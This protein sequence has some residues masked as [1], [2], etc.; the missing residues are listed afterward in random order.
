MPII[1]IAFVCISVKNEALLCR[2]DKGGLVAK[3]VAFAYFAFGDTG[4][5]GFVKTVEFVF[6]VFCLIEEP[7]AL[8]YQY[9]GIQ[10]QVYLVGFY[11]T[12]YLPKHSA[13]SS[14]EL[15]ECGRFSFELFGVVVAGVFDQQPFACSDV[16]LPQWDLQPFGQLL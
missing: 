5:I 4:G 8:L 15:F 3:L 2:R 1:R 6:G 16:A 13:E 7:L 12:K 10:V 14:L 11:F 9:S